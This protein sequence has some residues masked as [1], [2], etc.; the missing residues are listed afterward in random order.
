M[1]RIVFVDSWSIGLNIL[2]PI[3]EKLSLRNDCQL[4]FVHFDSLLDKYPNRLISERLKSNSFNYENWKDL[5]IFDFK[6]F[7]Y[8]VKK[9]F[10]SE[11]RPDLLIFISIHNLEQRYFLNVAN[12][13]EIPCVLIMHGA[14]LK[15]GIIPLKNITDKLFYPFSR[16]N[17]LRYYITLFNYYR[18]DLS[19]TF[20]IETTLLLL[21]II[22][23]REKYVNK[24]DKS[25]SFALRSICLITEND[26]VFFERYFNQ[27]E[28][29]TSFKVTGHLDNRKLFKYFQ[30]RDNKDA[31]INTEI[32]F[33]SQPLTSDGTILENKYINALQMASNVCNDLGFKF[34]LRPHPRDSEVF[35]KKV[36][37][38]V[39]LS[40]S[41]NS[42]EEDLFRS[43]IVVGIN[44][45]V[46]LLANQLR[47]PI[48][49]F[50]FG[51]ANEFTLKPN[52]ETSNVK[53]VN[54]NNSDDFFNAIT[55]LTDKNSNWDF[56]KLF[57]SD[58]VELI[59]D[60]VF[61]ILDGKK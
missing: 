61:K 2:E 17:R 28:E 49:I 53:I 13:Y 22:F 21:K 46:L 6:E 1:N 12:I 51:F 20:G 56:N 26:K 38:Q 60:E 15:D 27:T 31:D 7:N 11:E 52:D 24:L 18:K 29:T 25:E 50:D 54:Y 39:N 19:L 23:F 4:S 40:I 10:E 37:N 42:L 14:I 45:T 55:F 59:H 43:K 58:P 16:F 57:L 5:K 3:I 36:A 47:K 9:F 48:I 41:S 44:S 32:I 30:Y 35:I 34:L 8:S 33:F